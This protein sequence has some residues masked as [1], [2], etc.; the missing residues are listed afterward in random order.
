MLLLS[1]ANIAVIKYRYPEDSKMVQKSTGLH[2]EKN[3][4]YDM[5]FPN[6]VQVWPSYLLIWNPWF[7]FSM[8][9]KGTGTPIKKI[10]E[11]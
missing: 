6:K 7:Q 8:D 4:Q 11:C 9:T 10:G 1:T 2:C 3:S 5:I